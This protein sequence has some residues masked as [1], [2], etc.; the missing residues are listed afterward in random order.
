MA[1]INRIAIV[2]KSGN[3]LYAITEKSSLSLFKDL[4]D[5]EIIE[6]IYSYGDTYVKIDGIKVEDL[7]VAATSEESRLQSLRVRIQNDED[8]TKMMEAYHKDFILNFFAQ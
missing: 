8:F 4:D 1:I 5:K 3:R 6:D 7:N 2:S